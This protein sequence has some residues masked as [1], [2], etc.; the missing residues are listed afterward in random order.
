[1]ERARETARY[2]FDTPE[3]VIYFQKG[4]SLI[5]SPDATYRTE[6]ERIINDKKIA[7]FFRPIYSTEGARVIGYL[8]KQVPT[9]TY[10]ETMDEVKN[11]AARSGDAESLF[12]TLFRRT[13]P[14]F[15]AQRS[16]EGQLLF[17]PVR[18]DDLSFMMRIVSKSMKAKETKIVFLFNEADL[19]DHINF[20]SPETFIG[21]LTRIKA[22]GHEVGLLI[23][24]SE[25]GLPELIYSGFDRFACSFALQGASPAEIDGKI[26]VLLH[27]LPERLLRYHKP[28]IAT[29]I[30]SWTAIGVIVNSGISLLSSELIGKF[31]EM[32]EPLSP[33][34]IKKLKDA[35]R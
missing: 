32:I 31:D 19:R 35:S 22:K 13:L 28:I 16:D 14:L 10:F 29:D 17:F 33:K 18:V 15:I 7:Y 25:L 12:S 20:A 9:D 5:T 34:I 23:N 11:Y 2:A 26:R 4:K 27:A 30:E 6:I 1:M 3:K 8:S 21:E 24:K